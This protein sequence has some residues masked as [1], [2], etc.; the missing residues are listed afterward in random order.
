M[1]AALGVAQLEQID[2]LI[3]KKQDI[4]NKY[5]ESLKDIEGI[6]INPQQG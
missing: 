1:Q 5:N 3:E 4:V 6:T 2:E